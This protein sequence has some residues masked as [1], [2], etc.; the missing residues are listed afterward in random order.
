MFLYNNSSLW[1]ERCGKVLVPLLAAFFSFRFIKIKPLYLS[2]HFIHLTENSP[3]KRPRGRGLQDDPECLGRGWLS[4]FPEFYE[5]F[6]QVVKPKVE[7][8]GALIYSQ[9]VRSTSDNLNLWLSSELGGQ[10]QSYMT[11]PL[12][13]RIHLQVDSIRI[14]LNYRAPSWCQEIAWWYRVT[15]PTLPHWNWVQNPLQGD[16]WSRTEVGPRTWDLKKAL[17]KPGQFG[18]PIRYSHEC[19]PRTTPKLSL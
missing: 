6:Q 19:V 13:Y 14:E 5:L 16:S 17:G 7:V 11:K 18:H 15:P 12:T 10:V 8:M 9:L 4:G 3:R 2:C 1:K